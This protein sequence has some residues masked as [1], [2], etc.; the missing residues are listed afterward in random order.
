[1][2]LVVDSEGSIHEKHDEYNVFRQLAVKVVA[3]NIND[4]DYYEWLD[5]IP[6]TT[7]IDFPTSEF[8]ERDWVRDNPPLNTA[9][10]YDTDNYDILPT[11]ALLR[12][13]C[14]KLTHAFCAFKMPEDDTGNRLDRRHVFEGLE[15]STIQN[16]PAGDKSISIVKGLISRK[17]IDQPGTFLEKATGIDASTLHP[18]MILRGHRTTFYVLLDGYDVLRCSIDRSAVF[19]FRSDADQE[20]ESN[21]KKFREIELSLYPRI[22]DKIKNDPRVIQLIEYLRDSLIHKFNTNVIYEIKYQRGMKLLGLY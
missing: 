16:D 5:T 19:N 10:Y 15:K 14:S 17:D 21:W 8:K 3:D 20:D 18:A 22:S 9:V 13:S 12:T 11:G 6:A 1:M 7:K 2:A 4:H